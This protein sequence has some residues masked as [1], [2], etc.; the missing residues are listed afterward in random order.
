MS[1]SPGNTKPEVV[2]ER[3][4]A[5]APIETMLLSYDAQALM[6]LSQG[7]SVAV[8]TLLTI[9]DSVALIPSSPDLLSWA[10]RVLKVWLV[11]L[12]LWFL[13]FL[14]VLHMLRFIA[15]GIS[16]D[17]KGIKLWRLGVAIPWARVQAVG[18]ETEP[19][20]SRVF[21]LKQPARRLTI[22]PARESGSLAFPQY[23]ASFLFTPDKFM[24]LYQAILKARFGL[25][26]EP[27]DA[28]VCAAEDLPRVKR[29]HS[30]VRINR[31]LISA[32]IA[33]GLVF[34]LARKATVNYLYVSANQSFKSGNY[35]A[36]RNLL[37]RVTGIDPA[38]AHAWHNLAG[39]EFRLGDQE[40]AR[41][42][43]HR[44]LFLKPDLVE[45]KVSL[46]YLY[47]Q[48]RQF[49]K[50]NDL[51]K[52]VLR[53]APRHSPAL[54]NLADLNMRLGR[55]REAMKIARLVLTQE[56]SNHLANCLLAQGR[57]RLGKPDQALELLVNLNNQRRPGSQESFCRLVTGEVYL[58]LGQTARAA[59]LFESVLAELPGNAEA[60]TDLA[61]VRIAQGRLQEAD[62]LFYRASQPSGANPWPYLMRVEL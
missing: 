15:R 46:A 28:L 18:L 3:A 38:F 42:Y 8:A 36:A 60:M 32:I 31:A 61:R 21:C 62:E 9:P 54:V 41:Q 49:D 4:A 37:Q 27:V 11:A 50:A 22:Y 39:V 34:F 17:G 35:M 23:V 26:A 7:T 10:V 58:A 51:L 30:L 2:P 20:F 33:L 52:R 16:L 5:E 6:Q 12:I 40:K 48:Q 24:K 57:L 44:A 55:T 53:L 19:L 29:I 47:M 13:G 1:E 56:R 59:S 25:K 43:W 45:S 14:A